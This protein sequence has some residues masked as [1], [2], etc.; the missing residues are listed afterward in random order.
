MKNIRF[1]GVLLFALF[2]M[3]CEKDDYK[4]MILTVAP[5][6]VEYRY[7]FGE[8]EMVMGYAVTDSKGNKFAIDHISGFEDK[9]EDGYEYVIKVK[10]V[11][12]DKGKEPIQD[13]FGCYYYLV[14]II[15]KET[16]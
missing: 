4:I 5:E 6:K 7:P 10:A 1:L 14:K 16:K 13:L 8:P 12:K 3:A 9:Y 15:S 11:E 2:F